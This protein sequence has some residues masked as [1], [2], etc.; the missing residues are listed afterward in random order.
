MSKTWKTI[1]EIIPNSAK[2]ANDHTHDI[3]VNKA[4][5]YNVHFANIG[6]NTYHKTQEILHG[7]NVPDFRYGTVI[8]RGN[9]RFRPQPVDTETVILTIKNLNE[10]RSVGSD[11]IPMKFIKDS[12]HVSSLKQKKHFAI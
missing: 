7:A 12:L 10:T 8:L 2:N 4:N 6:K 5:E 3:D 1:R 11:G 9:N